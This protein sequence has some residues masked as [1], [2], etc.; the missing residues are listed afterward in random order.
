MNR[1]LKRIDIAVILTMVILLT[2]YVI[3]DVSP[4]WFLYLFPGYFI[5]T[6]IVTIFNHLDADGR[7][8]DD[9]QSKKRDL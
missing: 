5:V 7:L 1:I 9:P 2:G 3:R 4:P 8:I 6:S